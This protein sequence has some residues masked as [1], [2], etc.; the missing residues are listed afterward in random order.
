MAPPRRH[1]TRAPLVGYLPLVL[2]VVALSG[3]GFWLL[4]RL[5]GSQAGSAG[6]GLR[7]V[8]VAV[9][10]ARS[11]TLVVYVFGGSDPEYADNLRFFVNEAVKEG[12]NCDYIIVLQQDK[13][14]SLPEPLPSLPR[15]ARY[16]QH[17]NECFDIGTVGWVLQAHVPRRAAYRYF[18][19]LNSSVRGPFLPAYL[20]GAVHWTEPLLSKLNDRVKLVGPTINCGR[21][22]DLPP[23]VHVQS[24]VTATDAAGLEVLL[25]TGTVF[26]CWG[27]IHDTII[28]SEIGASSAIMAAGFGIDSLM[29]RYKGVD[30][31]DPAVQDH[32]CNG[33]LNPL[34]PGFN[35]GIN[36]EP[37]EVMFIKVK[38]AMLAAGN[39]PHATAAVKYAQWARLARE[40][41]ARVAGGAR[42]ASPRWLAAI[43]A[44]EWPQA[45]APEL[46]RE[47]QRRGQ[48]CFDH[49]FYIDS[50]YDLA[51]M[52][53]QPDPPA[54]AWEQFLGMGL[55]EGRPYR[56]TLEVAE[57]ETTLQL[58]KAE[59]VAMAV[60][61]ARAEL[62]RLAGAQR[63]AEAE[64][65]AATAGAAAA[66][67]DSAVLE[68][69]VQSGWAPK[70]GQTV[71]VPRLNK[72]AKVVAV[73]GTGGLTLQAGLL[74]VSARVDEVRQ[75]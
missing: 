1:R 25:A 48:A 41:A 56:F 70:L 17:A 27:H 34:Q 28:S 59:A 62:R 38:A 37:L 51:F 2:M 60:R 26:K 44:N 65:A 16:L 66:K 40:E 29:L 36:V 9:P 55:Y 5:L 72:R 47:A 58:Q 12:D 67:Q 10:Q 4:P 46:L 52:W 57:R 64:A 43:A 54:L 19:W 31:R 21:A 24:Y 11:R 74:K 7:L 35:D 53:E 13:D 45:R 3:W 6:K 61:S 20:S 50:G 8:P 22:Y 18:V 73:D 63:A 30:W 71:F 42:G 33:E 23:T 49:K 68:R 69:Q 15:N 32:A 14:L 39:W 75:Q